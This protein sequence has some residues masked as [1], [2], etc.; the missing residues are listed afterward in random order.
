MRRVFDRYEYDHG[1]II[2]R[3]GMGTVYKGT[4][5]QTGN[6]VAIKYLDPNIVNNNPTMVERFQ[7]EGEALRDL[8]HPNIVKMLGAGHC[9]AEHYIVMEYVS[10]GSLR[11]LLDQTPKL[12]VQRALY[13]G[14]DLADALTRAHRLKILHRD[15]K[16]ANILVASDGTPRL[17]DFG[18]A[19]VGASN[20]TAEGSLVG[21]LAYLSPESLT[22]QHIDERHD[23]WAFGVLLFEMLAG[24]RPYPQES[25]GQLV[26][27]ITTQAVPDLESIR[28]DVPISLVDLIYRMLEKDPNSRIRS[29]RMIG[30]ELEAIINGADTSPIGLSTS[31]QVRFARSTTNTPLPSSVSMSSLS[32]SGV[33]RRKVPKLHNFPAETTPFVGREKEL[34]DLTEIVQDPAQRLITLVGPGGVG[35]TRLAM[36]LGNA[37]LNQFPDGVYFIPLESVDSPMH[38]PTKI[39]ESLGLELGG[40]EM[41]MDEVRAFLKDKHA[42]L[43]MDNLEQLVQGGQMMAEGMEQMPHV[44]VVATTRERLRL[45]GEQVYEVDSMIIPPQRTTDPTKLSEYPSVQLFINNAKRNAP[46]FDL[47]ADNTVDVNRIINLV[48]GMPLGIELA[49]GWMEMLPVDEIANEIEQSLDFLETDLRDVPERHRSMRAVF[50]HSWNL[51]TAD[52]QDAFIKLSLFRDGFVREA[53]QAVTG[54]SLRTLTTLGNKSLVFRAPDG[55]FA[56]PKMLRQYA[57]ERFYAHCGDINMVTAK[58]VEH[59]ANYVTSLSDIFGTSKEKSAA[60][61]YEKEAENIRHAWKLA[62]KHQHLEPLDKMVHPVYDFHMSR[63]LF[64]EGIAMLEELTQSLKAHGAD[65]TSTYWHG[66]MLLSGIMGRRGDYIKAEKMAAQCIAFFQQTED[67]IYLG[68]ALNTHAY[69]LM[70]LGD[71]DRARDESVK[72]IEMAQRLNMTDNVN[73]YGMACGNLGYIEFLAGDLEKAKEIYEHL[74]ISAYDRDISPLGY[75]FATNN[76]GEI[77]QAMGDY[78]TAQT[79]YETAY[80]VFKEL[81]QRRGM[82]FT[83]NNLAGLYQIRGQMEKAKELY[84]KAHRFNRET[85]DRAGIGH[86]LSAMGNIALFH[87]R[88]YEEALRYYTEAKNLRK[89]IGDRAGYA[90]SLTEVGM[91]LYML[92]RAEES[93]PYY[94]EAYQLGNE[95]NN[96]VVKSLACIGMGGVMLFDGDHAAAMTYFREAIESAQNYR[97]DAGMIFVVAAMAIIFEERD[98]NEHAAQLIGFVEQHGDDESSQFTKPLLENLQYTLRNKMGAGYTQAFK[99]GQLLETDHVIDLVEQA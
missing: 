53:V 90:Q 94:E 81:R 2:G 83:T 47:T 28:S 42:L 38:V 13:I 31:Q 72:V 23:I 68:E 20:M 29:V 46:D 89:E 11:D 66:Y 49:T 19:R 9:D 27:A 37:V 12:I 85:G 55:R 21:T 82:A 7:R 43:I 87:E 52:E 36:A 32:T 78:D 8:N 54:T 34:T 88:H 71:Y 14:L 1:N 57:E 17:T 74:I 5:T 96:E 16:P 69:T 35:K 39:A 30:A 61:A 59:Y 76:L 63:S 18:V 80:E 86:S 44:T 10:G 25:V 15:I 6:A 97:F 95:M 60:E 3:G 56:V 93:R 41:P 67:E 51:M 4:D 58:Y 73:L 48:H 50:E 92:G 98:L 33:G 77:A 64:L 45:R 91:T 22:G 62:L 75:A 26:A 65:N 79:S 24:Q 99:R 70:M 40:G 84:N